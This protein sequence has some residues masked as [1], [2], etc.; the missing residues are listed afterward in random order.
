L[1]VKEKA[2]TEEAWH[3]LETFRVSRRGNTYIA[4]EIAFALDHFPRVPAKDTADMVGVS[5][6]TVRR[7]KAKRADRVHPLVSA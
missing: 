4:M 2:T 3:A 6:S 7:H 5:V 1:P